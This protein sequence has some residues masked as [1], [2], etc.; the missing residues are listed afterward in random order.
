MISVGPNF[1]YAAK[2]A[3]MCLEG[4]TFALVI[5]TRVEGE[6]KALR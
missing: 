3:Y 1:K 5:I 2:T 4:I 6:E